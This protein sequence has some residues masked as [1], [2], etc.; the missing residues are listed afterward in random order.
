VVSYGAGTKFMR[1]K[2]IA[3]DHEGVCVHDC[4]AEILARRAFMRFLYLQAKVA[5]RVETPGSILPCAD[6][7]S[8][9]I[10][11]VCQEPYPHLA[12]REGVSFHMYTSAMPCGN[13][14]DK[15]WAKGA[16]E[17]TIQGLAPLEV[18]CLP[19]PPLLV[20]ARH[21]GQL[22]RLVKRDSSRS[23]QQGVLATEQP[24]V[25][26]VEAW[27][28][29]ASS[30]ACGTS[31]EQTPACPCSLT[32][33][34][35]HLR[36]D[37]GPAGSHQQEQHSSHGASPTHDLCNFKK[38]RRAHAEEIRSHGAMNITTPPGTALPHSQS[39]ST[40]TC[41]DKLMRW[42]V[43]GLQ[44]ALLKRLLPEPVYLQ[45]ITIGHKFSRP[46]ATRALCCRIQPLQP[47]L[48]HLNDQMEALAAHSDNSESHDAVWDG[49]SC[50]VEGSRCGGAVWVQQSMHVGLGRMRVNHPCIMC[51]AAIFDKGIFDTSTAAQ[52]SFGSTVS[53]TWS[54]G[55]ARVDVVDGTT[56]KP[57]AAGQGEHSLASDA[58][59]DTRID[60]TVDAIPEATGKFWATCQAPYSLGGDARAGAIHE[61][62]EQPLA[63]CQ[64]Q[65]SLAGNAG[66]DALNGTTGQAP[67]TCSSQHALADDARAAAIPVATGHPLLA[68]QGRHSRASD[69]RAY[70]VHRTTEQTLAACQVQHSLVCRRALCNLYDACSSALAGAGKDEGNGGDHWD[71]HYSSL[72]RSTRWHVLARELFERHVDTVLGLE[73]PGKSRNWSSALSVR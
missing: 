46:H 51:T 24:H 38:Q 20:Q 17:Q 41:S 45:S 72:K 52:A 3:A 57:P 71:S 59:V 43:L 40:W 47:L 10:L 56:G 42:N 53:L 36:H 9:C 19:H 28:G 68:C 30:S 15:R 8:F 39:G 5:L 50:A 49:A 65:H 23:T 62:T 6:D 60:A 61:T 54:A 18:P 35:S 12:V 21:E 70:A 16:T 13:A 37:H 22:L 48:D 44:G 26:R 29:A 69:G 14:A 66:A 25:L 1:Q 2:D 11:E 33:Q 63:V 4:H 67:D 64:G 27:D 55:D 31:A 32:V 73:K 7:T 34:T 58:R